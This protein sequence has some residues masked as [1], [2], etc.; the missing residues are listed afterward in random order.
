MLEI[1]CNQA[2]GSHKQIRKIE[3]ELLLLQRSD[4]MPRRLVT[5]PGVGPIGATAFAASVTDPAQFKSGR[6]FAAWLG[7]TPPQNSSGGKERLGR[8]PLSPYVFQARLL[9]FIIELLDND[10]GRY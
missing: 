4:D 9:W 6:Q 2:L 8:R 7:L 3:R 5:I 10:I 1:L